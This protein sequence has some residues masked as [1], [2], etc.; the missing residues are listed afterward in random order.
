MNHGA[1]HHAAV[2]I[3]YGMMYT[4]MER[5]GSSRHDVYAQAAA[6]VLWL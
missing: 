6:A 5:S 3:D 4:C 2:V 1:L